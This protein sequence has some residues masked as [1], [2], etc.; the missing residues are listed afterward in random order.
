[1]VV[2][3]GRPCRG[4]VSTHPLP[5]GLLPLV[6]STTGGAGWAFPTLFLSP[7]VCPHSPAHRVAAPG[8][9]G[10]GLGALVGGRHPLPVLIHGRWAGLPSPTQGL[11]PRPLPRG[12][13]PAQPHGSLRTSP[14]QLCE[15]QHQLEDQPVHAVPRPPGGGAERGKDWGHPFPCCPTRSW[16]PCLPAPTCRAPGSA[17][18]PVPA[19][20]T[21][22]SGSTPAAAPPGPFPAT[23]AGLFS[24][25]GLETPAPSATSPG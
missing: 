3:L 23:P 24:V 15:L 16:S 17:P 11:Q 10:W 19:P 22:F 7:S 6:L 13:G 21:S 8:Q 25:S 2:S 20:R 14:G 9:V 5:A 12:W 1:M 18:C 4:G